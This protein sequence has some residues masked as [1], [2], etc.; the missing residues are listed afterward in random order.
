MIRYNFHISKHQKEQLE[1]LKSLLPG[2][3]KVASMIREAIDDYITK[4]YKIDVVME[5]LKEEK[6]LRVIY[7]EAKKE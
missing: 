3:P 4:C 2:R 7:M 6:H 1:L 5:K